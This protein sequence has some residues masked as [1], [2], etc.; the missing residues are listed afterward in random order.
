MTGNLMKRDAKIGTEVKK[1]NGGIRKDEKDR[2]GV[3]VSMIV[4]RNGVRVQR[5]RITPELDLWSC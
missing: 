4:D 3:N 1:K 5:N 2:K